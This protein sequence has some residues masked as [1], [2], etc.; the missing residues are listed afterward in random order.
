MN[1]S[2]VAPPFIYA[3]KEGWEIPIKDGKIERF[4]ERI[5]RAAKKEARE[6]LAGIRRIFEYSNKLPGVIESLAKQYTGRI[7]SMQERYE[8]ILMATGKQNLI[9]IGR[10]A[11]FEV[12]SYI[13]GT[14]TVEV[15]ET[16]YNMLI[17]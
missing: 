11:E 13:D 6:L 5:S 16:R 15:H 4:P 8:K 7:E 3:G 10:G 1:F 17:K 14:Y 12:Q 9:W 2:E